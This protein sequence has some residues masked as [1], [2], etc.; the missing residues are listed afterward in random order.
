[1]SYRTLSVLFAATVV[2]GATASASAELPASIAATGDTA[3]ATFHAEGAQIY[4]CKLSNDG[5]LAWQF[6][7]PVATLLFDGKTV[8]RHYAGPNWVHIDGSSVTAKPIGSAPGQTQADIPW[9]KL[10]V[11]GHSGTGMFS[12]VTT[13]L[14]INT[15]GG[16]VAGACEQ[17]GSYRS[18][19][20]AADYVFLRKESS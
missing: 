14:R 3:V 15:R 1:M 17:I 5:K 10:E 16:V 6:R 13:V 4:E 9:L 20:Y 18:A 7:E 2:V 12:S 11:I 8:G 19:P